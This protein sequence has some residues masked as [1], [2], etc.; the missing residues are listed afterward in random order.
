MKQGSVATS[1]LAVA[2]FLLAMTVAGANAQA[3][4]ATPPTAQAATAAPNAAPDAQALAAKFGALPALN[5]ISLSPD[6]TQISFIGTTATQRR[7]L[8]VVGDAE[9][10]TPRAI[11][12]SS[13]D[14]DFLNWCQW[15]TNDR[16]VCHAS[17]RDRVAGWT[18]TA[19]TILGVDSTGRNLTRLSTRESVNALYADLRG[20]TVIDWLPD[21]P[22]SILMTRTN[23]PEMS[24]G[25]RLAASAEGLGVDRVDIRSGRGTRVA[26]PNREATDYTTDGRGNVRIMEMHPHDG[27]GRLEPNIRFLY[28][29]SSGGNWQPLSTYNVNTREGLYPLAVD[30]ATNRAIGFS[31]ANGRQT[32]VSIALDGSGATETIYA[33]PQVDVDGLIRI[34]RSRRIVGVSYVTERRHAVMTDPAIARMANALS[35]A[36]DQREIAIVDASADESR[37]L[38]LAS[39]DIDPGSYYL[40]T[41]AARQLR[42]LMSVRPQLDGMTLAPMQAVQYPAADGTMV[43]AYLTLP[44]GRSDARGLPAIVMPHGG[45]SARDEWGFDWLSQYFAQLGYAVLQPNYRGSSGYGDAW[46]QRNGFQSWRSAIGDIVDGGRWLS[47]TQGAD[48]A[49]LSIVGWSYG[50]YAALQSA[51]T[52]PDVFRSV[53]AIA[54]VTDLNQFKAEARDYTNSRLIEDQI[55]TGPHTVEGSPARQANRITAPVLMFHG[56]QDQNV[57]IAQSRTMLRALQGA[58]KRVELIEYPQLAH[59]LESPTA[60]IDML[61]RIAAFLPH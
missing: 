42:P 46:Y 50:G 18:M 5:D 52:A 21:Q 54:P 9:G 17:V 29:P 32:A 61:Q 36:L 16:L 30:G 20:G 7:T 15:A 45:P 4:T 8:Y 31:R 59:N 14:P 51:A 41:P 49:K 28:R 12:N 23:V 38:V 43:P 35:R 27:T 60:R 3:N 26:N 37:Y 13:G 24:T 1:R 2:V 48:P 56:D 11:V 40:Y 53:V 25:T 47:G 10:A 39:S 19:A 6:G 55:G 34:G 58:G 22:G 33:H 57:E 44:P